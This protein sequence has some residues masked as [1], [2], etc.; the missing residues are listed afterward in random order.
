MLARAIVILLLATGFA[1]A[2]EDISDATRTQIDSL[3]AEKDARTPAQQKLDS[4]LVYFT[5]Q[6]RGEA[7]TAAVPTLELH[8][9]AG[10]DGRVLVDIKANVSPDLL[11]WITSS[12]G[13]VISHFAQFQAIRALV[14]I[15][16]LE[17]LAGHPQVRFVSPAAMATTNLG[18]VTSEGDRTHRAN[19]ARTTFAVNGTGLKVGVLSDGVNSLAASKANGNLN[20]N[21]TVISGQAGS[22]DEGTAM[23]EIVQ[24]VVPG[25]QVYFATAFNGPAS[26]ASNILALQ[27]AGCKVIVDDVSYFYESPFQDQVISQAVSTVSSLGVLYFSSARNSGS[28]DKNTSGTWEGDFVDGGAATVGSKPARVHSFSGTIFNSVTSAASTDRVDLFWA[29]PLGASTND[30]DLF[31]TNAAGTVLRSSTNIQNGTQDPYESVSPLNTGERIVIV[32]TTAATSRFLHLDTGRAQI[33]INTQGNV[34]GHNAAGAAN[35]FSVAATDVNNSPSPNFF[36]GGATNPVETFSSDGP[37]RMFF[38]PDGTAIT[39]GNFSAT[40][41]AVLQKPDFT[42]ADG[43]VTSVSGFSPFYGTSAAAPHAAGIAALL[44]SYNPALTPAQVRSLLSTT[45]LD[46]G[47]AGFDRTTGSGIIMALQAMQ[48]APF[49]PAN[50]FNLKPTTPGGWSDNIVVS[51]VAGTNTDAA[52]YLSTD[53]LFLDWAVT[54]SGT[55]AIN[56][57]FD[58]QLFV[59]GGLKNTWNLAAPTASGAIRATLDFSLGSL[60]PGTHTLRIVA[61]AGNVIAESNE[62]DNDYTKTIFVRPANDNF[63]NAQTLAGNFG[64]VLGT[65]VTCTKETGEPNHAGNAGGASAWYQWTPTASG[66]ATIDTFGSDFDT[67]VGVYTGTA[68]GALTTIASNDDANAGT[69]QSQVTF[70]AVAGTNYH[71][72]VDGFSTSGVIATGNITLHYSGPGPTATPTT[73]QTPTTTPTP[74][75]TPTVTQTPTRTPTPTST[76]TVTPTPTNTPTRT[77]TPTNTPTVT[78]TPTNAPTRT[79]TP[80]NTPTVTP[81]PTNTPTRT[82]TPTSTPTVTPTPTNTPTSTPTP[83]NTPTVTPTPTNTPTSTPTPTPSN[84][85]TVTPT[86]T[87]TPTATPTPTH[88]PTVTPTATSTPTATPTA[89][90]TPTNTPTA[91]NTPTPTSTPTVTPSPTSTPTSTPTPT[92]TPTVTPTAT[93][94]PTPTPT[95]FAGTLSANASQ[96]R[97]ITIAKSTILSVCSDPGN[98]ALTVIS[99]GPTSAQGGTVSMTT[100]TV[101]YS[102]PNPP[103]I[104]ADSFSYTIQNS[105]GAVASGTVNVT[106]NPPAYPPNAITVVRSGSSFTASFNGVPGLSYSIE[107]S[108]DLT[109]AWLSLTPPGTVTADSDGLFQFSDTSGNPKRF[110]RAR[111][112]P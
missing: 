39:P 42:A 14:P 58:V 90:S 50:N 72:A 97:P 37:R 87:N 81:T 108:D 62:I 66:T 23:M 76:P 71:I 64:T 36:V 79:P 67:I 6:K 100:S 86:P 74:T 104:G 80:S 107:F 91:T 21:A 26:M 60:P 93:V 101:S 3:L 10:A 28:K 32:K 20:A 83:S 112:L 44:W 53:T 85:P 89:T 15:G 47:G 75:S 38:N 70:A 92:T 8:I 31:V 5:K 73:T 78:P 82:P 94:T 61:D 51:T 41:G 9:K 33:S 59:D 22:G 68:V 56:A 88:T 99:V 18:S 98:L 106:V 27:A 77:P 84:T 102:P 111:A 95:P 63:V 69:T 2:A 29:D 103:F 96:G 7:I 45:A 19:T 25:A 49:P 48:A 57:A 65:N 35:A 40:G 12:G 16:F 17:A 105:S 13:A 109:S 46:I 52:N 55:S 24:D 34:R 54:N 4:Q 110:Y 11:G 30:Y 43:G 1:R